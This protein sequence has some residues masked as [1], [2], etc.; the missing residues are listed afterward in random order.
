MIIDFVRVSRGFIFKRDTFP[1]GPI[2]FFAQPSEWTFV[3]KNAVYTIQTLL[4]DGIL[5]SRTLGQWA[6]MFSDHPLFLPLDLSLLR[7]LAVMAHRRLPHRP[8]VLDWR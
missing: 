6:V 7:C 1:G 5:V 4:G 8:V 2:A 3:A